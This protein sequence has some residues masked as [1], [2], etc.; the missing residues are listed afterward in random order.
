MCPAYSSYFGNLYFLTM[1]SVIFMLR[2]INFKFPSLIVSV[3]FIIEFGQNNRGKAPSYS[4]K[5]LMRTCSNE[6]SCLHFIDKN[7]YSSYYF[8]VFFFI[9]RGISSIL[10]YHR[11]IGGMRCHVSFFWC[12]NFTTLLNC[13]HCIINKNLI[14]LDLM[15]IRGPPIQTI[16][17]A[18]CIILHYKIAK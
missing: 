14:K 6:N 5:P 2:L 3:F 10:K 18:R 16:L 8:F 17:P 9:Q 13:H 11:L 12:D 4:N 15:E 7:I 1:L